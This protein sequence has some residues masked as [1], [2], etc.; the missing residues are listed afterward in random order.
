MV[1]QRLSVERIAMQ[2]LKL[3]AAAYLKLLSVRWVRFREPTTVVV[4]VHRIDSNN[5]DTLPTSFM[6]SE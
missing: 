2:L 4:C 6:R 3:L 5:Q 1:V